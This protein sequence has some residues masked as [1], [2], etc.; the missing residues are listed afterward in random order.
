M[1]NSGPS[2]PSTQARLKP[3][4]QRIHVHA[5][6]SQP[7]TQLPEGNLQFQSI[8]EEH[9]VFTVDMFP[10]SMACS[11]DQP[12]ASLSLHDDQLVTFAQHVGLSQRE[13]DFLRAAD[14]S[15]PSALSPLSPAIRDGNGRRVEDKGRS[16]EVDSGG[17]RRE[18]TGE[19]NQLN[20]CNKAESQSQVEG[21][22]GSSSNSRSRSERSSAPRHHVAM[23]RTPPE[24][25]LQQQMGSLEGVRQ[26]RFSDRICSGDR[27]TSPDLE[28][29][30][31]QPR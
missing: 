29:R 28:V 23:S 11:S 25:G 26:V 6:P 22:F 15:Q 13:F 7:R 19:I 24:Q 12:L 14:L 8:A 31:C 1:K 21:G 3:V 20:Q 27:R 9:D 18:R 4:D 16:E 17:H 5:E 2:N 10:A 30:P